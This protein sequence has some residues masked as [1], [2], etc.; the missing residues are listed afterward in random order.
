[1]RAIIEL[2]E[3]VNVQSMLT[4]EEKAYRLELLDRMI[5][6]GG[7]VD[8]S[9]WSNRDRSMLERLSEKMRLVMDGDDIAFVYPVSGHP[10]PHRVTLSDGRSF[11]AMC[12][13]DAL[14]S[15][16]TFH[17]DTVID[18]TCSTTGQPVHVRIKNGQLESYEPSTLHAIHVD[19][20][21]VTNWA[22]S[23]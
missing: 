9:G 2:A 14:G 11:Y 13:I 16:F 12:A 6:E 17:L 23:C 22:G 20:N 10:T 15:A 19:L 7:P 3:V 4:E 5:E 1:M 8:T 21:K 18:S